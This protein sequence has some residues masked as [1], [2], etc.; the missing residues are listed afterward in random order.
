MTLADDID[1]IPNTYV[2]VTTAGN[3]SPWELSTVSGLHKLLHTW[4]IN[5]C[6]HS[7]IYTYIYDSCF[8]KESFKAS[9]DAFW[10][11]LSAHKTVFST[12]MEEQPDI[13]LEKPANNLL[14]VN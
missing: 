7:Q 12:Q 11:L 5:I 8:H 2:I 9:R 6:R 1:L 4:Y 3:S 10:D 13:G 14:Q